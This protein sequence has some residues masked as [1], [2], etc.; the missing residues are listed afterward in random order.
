MF[1][2]GVAMKRA[3]LRREDPAADE[4]EITRRINLWLRT[5]PGAEYGDAEGTPTVYPDEGSASGLEWA[6]NPERLQLP[7]AALATMQKLIDDPPPP[8]PRLRAAAKRRT[9]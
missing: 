4:Q 8:S 2:P 3:Q 5:R 1:E 6:R 7:A 9:T